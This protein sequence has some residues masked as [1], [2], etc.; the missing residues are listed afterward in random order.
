MNDDEAYAYYSDPNNHRPG[1]RV[2][3]PFMTNPDPELALQELV[4]GLG[5]EAPT[6]CVS[7]R[8][9]TNMDLM[10]RA[11]QLTQMLLNMEQALDPRTQEA[12]DLHS[13]REAVRLELHRRGI[14]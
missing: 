12:R 10:K 1:K 6:D 7:V 3:N 13:E 14:I 4:D 9:R 2:R 5:I 8:D 11:G